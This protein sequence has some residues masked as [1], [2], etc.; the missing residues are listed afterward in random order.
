MDVGAQV[1]LSA[2]DHPGA[3]SRTSRRRGQID[4]ALGRF[5]IA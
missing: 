2:G 3:R 5:A 1:A 4:Q